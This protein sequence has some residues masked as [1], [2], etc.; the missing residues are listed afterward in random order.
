MIDNLTPEQ[1]TQIP[2]YRE[3]WRNIG[4]STERIERSSATEA[5][6]NLYEIRGIKTPTIAWFDSP[7][8]ALLT[9]A[10]ILGS[11]ITNPIGKNLK[12][13]LGNVLIKELKGQ[14]ASKYYRELTTQ[15]KTVLEKQLKGQFQSQIKQ[16]LTERLRKELT[17]Q[18]GAEFKG[19]YKEI[20]DLIA[21]ESIAPEF[22]ACWGGLFDFARTELK[23][24]LDEK[25]WLAFQSV[26]NSCGW[27]FPFENTVIVCDR[28]KKLLFNSKGILHA[29]AEPAISF[30]DDYK[31]YAYSGVILPVQYG[32]LPPYKWHSKWLLKNHPVE[33]KR[34]II[35]AIGK[36]QIKE[37]LTPEEF[38]LVW[39][40][41]REYTQQQKA[42]E[43]EL[44]ESLSTT[45]IREPQQQVSSG[46]ASAKNN[47]KP[48]NRNRIK[49]FSPE[50]EKRIKEFDKK[51]E[52]L[53]FQKRKKQ[54]EAELEETI[55]NACLL[56][57]KN[58][59]NLEVTF[60]GSPAQGARQVIGDEVLVETLKKL[61]SYLKN[62]SKNQLR[63]DAVSHLNHKDLMTAVDAVAEALGDDVKSYVGRMLN[64]V[65]I[66]SPLAELGERVEREISSQIDPQLKE[67]FLNGLPSINK[68]LKTN[69]DNKVYH[70]FIKQITEKLQAGINR[71]VGEDLERR[72]GTTVRSL[73]VSKLMDSLTEQLEK[74]LY[75]Q[76]TDLG[77]YYQLGA[78]FDFCISVLDC[79]C[80]AETWSAFQELAANCPWIYAR[81]NR[82]VVARTSLS[83]RAKGQQVKIKSAS[84]KKSP[85]PLW[86]K[87]LV[88]SFLL[89]FKLPLLVV[90]LLVNLA[91]LTINTLKFLAN[92]IWYILLLPFTLLRIL[93][94]IPAELFMSVFSSELFEFLIR[95][96]FFICPI[97]PSMLAAILNWLF[98]NLSWVHDIFTWFDSRRTTRQ[99]L[100][101]LQTT[102]FDILEGP[103]HNDTVLQTT[104]FN[105]PGGPLHTEV[106]SEGLLHAEGKPA[107]IFNDGR[108]QYFHHGVR[109]RNSRYW[110]HP[111]HWRTRWLLT[112]SDPDVFDVVIEEIGYDRVCME[113]RTITLDSW[114]EYSLLEFPDLRDPNDF[115]GIVVLKMTCPST[116]SVHALRV[117]PSII[118]AREAIRWANWG[119]D[120]EEFVVET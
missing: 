81:D 65:T 24:N 80:D 76:F 107:V 106:D 61:V 28:P 87:T 19:K 86:K 83:Y 97:P 63:V 75:S 101:V 33:L 90:S 77:K 6:K 29:E 66:Y 67:Q 1:I 111:R 100:T 27:I 98:N 64:S 96:F 102:R 26:V 74:K 49:R 93:A 94:T 51:W 50:Q 35:K 79:K 118:T 21:S 112:E 113:L 57:P 58:T 85:V 3:K 46:N 17:S 117:P 37:E 119:T 53:A 22:L 73:L 2:A 40:E 47:I 7:Y 23:C 104:R 55:K 43:R 13:E 116:G 20:I 16:E 62:K 89:V 92:T 42:K 18:L 88:S 70:P 99:N 84:E 36:A 38:K 82:C 30:A 9:M 109:L 110:V 56:I 5:I 12:K 45:G 25:K 60:C 32:M 120:P 10:P 69:L 95:C 71:K 39:G 72:L 91:E 31:I 15:L 41:Q 44:Q 105:I 48:L 34:A 11:Q 14:I 114:R 8:A 115:L 108:E 103:L 59:F 52:N 68:K 4:L 78:W 54:T